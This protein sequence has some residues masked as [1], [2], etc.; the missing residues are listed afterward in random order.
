MR[1]LTA[2]LLVFTVCLM[3]FCACKKDGKYGYE[4]NPAFTY[5]TYEGQ[6]VENIYELVGTKTNYGITDYS[7]GYTS[8]KEGSYTVVVSKTADGGVVAYGHIAGKVDNGGIYVYSPNK[9]D[10]DIVRNHASEEVKKLKNN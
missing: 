10:W 1:R 4:R 8:D 3:F 5:G 6:S 9:E 2:L 7:G